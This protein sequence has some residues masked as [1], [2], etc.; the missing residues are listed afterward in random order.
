MGCWNPSS[1]KSEVSDP[2]GFC[3]V[4]FLHYVLTIA[5][6]RIVIRITDIL[7]YSAV[8]LTVIYV[9]RFVSDLVRFA[10]H[11][12]SIFVAIF[13]SDLLPYLWEYLRAAAFTLHYSFSSSLC[14]IFV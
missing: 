1:T 11:N 2:A 6:L 10:C 5:L 14:I 3:Q 4:E 12:L 9:L 13:L 8:V 7:E